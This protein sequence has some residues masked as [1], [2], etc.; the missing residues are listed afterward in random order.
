MTAL[1]EIRAK[2]ID[3]YKKSEFILLPVIKFLFAYIVFTKLNSFLDQFGTGSTLAIISK[4]Q[5]KAVLSLI[6]AFVP[7][8][9]F[10]MFIAL[11]SVARITLVSIEAGIITFIVLMVFYFMFLS[12]FKDQAIFSVVTAFA[13]S[14]NIPYAVPIIAGIFI[15][16]VTIV[17][18]SVGIIVYF[19]SKSLNGLIAMKSG[20]MVDLPFLL[21]DMYK[22]FISQLTD[23]KAMILMVF[24]FAATVTATYFVAKLEMVY[25]HYIAI[26]FGAVIM[27]FGFGIGNLVLKADVSVLS[28]FL[29]VI[30]AVIISGIILFMRFSL[31]YKKV[32]KL[33]FEDDDYYYYVKAIPKIKVPKSDKETKTIE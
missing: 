5:V 1:L 11:I 24:V 29:G 25:I 16:P 22:Y 7:G 17:P 6:V 33:Q 9:W 8:L 26:A 3:L 30:V 31:D 23:N 15:G 12:M 10:A 14:I 2:V 21:L 19:L 32:E 18:I 27:L 4:F 13:L 20:S 28:V